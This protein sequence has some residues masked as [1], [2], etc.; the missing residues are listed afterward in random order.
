MT[1]TPEHSQFELFPQSSQNTSGPR[2]AAFTLRDL[3][4]S[5]ENII[6]VCI[7]FI[8]AVVL[9]F[10]LGVERG[11]RLAEKA[12]PVEQETLVIEA[13]PENPDVTVQKTEPA[14]ASRQARETTKSSPEVQ[15]QEF[16]PVP[17]DLK[18]AIDNQY[19]IQVASF[20]QEKYAQEEASNLQKNGFESFVLLKGSH[21]IV[22]VGKFEEMGQAKKFS[23]RLKNKYKDCLVRRL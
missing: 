16:I 15:Q 6:V 10:S 7:F 9:F 19:T 1:P 3:T 2:G 12:G 4:I 14:A 13:S 18:E 21:T 11:K 17:N 22:C 20:K 8:M 23:S 5:V